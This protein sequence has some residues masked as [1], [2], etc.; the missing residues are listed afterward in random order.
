VPDDEYTVADAAAA[1]SRMLRHGV[2]DAE[3][4]DIL[5][6]EYRED[7]FELARLRKKA[8]ERFED[9][10]ELFFDGQGLRY[11]TPD[12]IARARAQRLA[13]FGDKAVDLACGV[14]IQLAFLA[15]VFD[16][17]IGVEIDEDTAK[18]ARRN[19]GAL[20]HEGTIFV[21]D[22]L[23]R[24]VRDEV[25]AVDVIVCD[26]ARGPE[27][28]ER[29]IG[30]LSPDLRDVH[31]RWADEATA[32]CYELPPMIDPDHVREQF[33]AELEYTSL[34]RDLN[35]LALYGQ[36]AKRVDRSALVLPENER[37]TSEDS[38]RSVDRVDEPDEILHLVD[39]T[40]L[41][42]ELLEQLAER[43]DA[44]NLFDDEHPRRTLLTSDQPADSAFVRDFEVID[45]HTWNLMGL[46]H[47]LKR[48]EADSVTLR[49]NIEPDRYWDVR[50][51]LEEGL[52]GDE[53][54][55][56]FRVEAEG[57]IARPLDGHHPN[58]DD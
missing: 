54:L 53:Q 11:A 15:E 46:R 20:D 16:E 34:N 21:G 55:H 49:S 33:D 13:E 6:E 51:A 42:A 44:G 17:A 35:R 48:H 14:G 27:A 1:A 32:Y 9:P 58:G 4:K 23:D 31:E 8:S 47:K 52:D 3:I 41:Q 5:P 36:Q 7:A 25:G 12:T 28:E 30:D 2:S 24:A 39:R 38:R 40:V 45:T 50:N 22:C 29:R 43:V 10:W 19:L 18:R 57:I 37:L 26:P 56:L